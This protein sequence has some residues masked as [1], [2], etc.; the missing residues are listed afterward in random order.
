MSTYT[1]IPEMQMR[2]F[3]S[4]NDIDP[5][6][7][8]MNGNTDV[9]D[10][11]PPP[12]YDGD[13]P[14]SPD[15]MARM[16]NSAPNY[17]ETFEEPDYNGYEEPEHEEP[18]Y[19]EPEY[20]DFDGT[21]GNDYEEP[22]YE[23]P[24]Y[25]EPEYEDFDGTDGTDYEEPEHEEPEYEEPEYEDFDG[26]DGSDG[27]ESSYEEPEHE[28]PEHEEPEYEDF[29]DTNK[30]LEL[31]TC[32]PSNLENSRETF[33]NSEKYSAGGNVSGGV[34][35]ALV[36]NSASVA[37]ESEMNKLYMY[38]AIGVIILMIIY[39]LTSKNK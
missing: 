30:D 13:A 27:T 29:T 20:E 14:M 38:L 22:E 25:E 7:A 21:E 18:E 28:E 31:W 15:M 11:S 12:M 9:P 26:T 8:M 17:R 23:E 10:S 6:D 5:M 16:V 32:Y 33:E 4:F 2:S 1:R 19:E 36:K 37:N 34:Q 3:E 39:L 35:G 24:E